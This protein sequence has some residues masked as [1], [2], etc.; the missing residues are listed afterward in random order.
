MEMQQ[1]CDVIDPRGG[2]EVSL[3]QVLVIEERPPPSL[4]LIDGNVLWDR[5][6]QH[7]RSYAAREREGERVKRIWHP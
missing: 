6:A 4:L 2:G 5:A 1:L 7:H 3:Q